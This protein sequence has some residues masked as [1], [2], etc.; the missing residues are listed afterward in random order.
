MINVKIYALVV[1][2]L[3]T[4]V[5][6]MPLKA[7]FAVVHDVPVIGLHLECDTGEADCEEY[8]EGFGKIVVRKKPDVVLSPSTV[9]EFYFTPGESG[10]DVASITLTVSE[11]EKLK[12]LTSANRQ[13]RIAIVIGGKV[14]SAPVI[15]SEISDRMQITFGMEGSEV[16]FKEVPWALEMAKRKKSSGEL[17]NLIKVVSYVLI[18]L[19]L[20]GG[21]V[22]VAF[23]RGRKENGDVA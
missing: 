17:Q 3:T 21:S 12:A 16:A 22:Y 14:T 8:P 1:S 20:L 6:V 9:L 4:V 5:A 19:I 13:K 2:V 10:R 15:Q 7:A 11:A 18:A 23:V